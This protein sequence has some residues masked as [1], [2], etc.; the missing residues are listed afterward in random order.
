M[1]FDL[2][3]KNDYKIRTKIMRIIKQQKINT[4]LIPE[5]QKMS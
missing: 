2:I 4:Q 1:C 5:S 3:T